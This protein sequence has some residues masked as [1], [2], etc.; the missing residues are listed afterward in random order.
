[1]ILEGLGDNNGL[2]RAQAS[3]QASALVLAYPERGGEL[4]AVMAELA[5]RRSF[6]RATRSP[7]G[8]LWAC[9]RNNMDPPSATP[10]PKQPPPITASEISDRPVRDAVKELDY[11]ARMA[12]VEPEQ[13][14]RGALERL[15]RELGTDDLEALR[16][17][18]IEV[19]GEN[20][21]KSY[22]PDKPIKKPFAYFVASLRNRWRWCDGDG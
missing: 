4:V 18:A 3:A 2:S 13:V 11:A 10:G 7:V 20:V 1:M 22:D 14:D 15:V 16:A 19:G 6:E 12:K 17:V 21:A 8:Y 9:V 5:A